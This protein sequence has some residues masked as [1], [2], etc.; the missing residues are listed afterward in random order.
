MSLF[1]KGLKMDTKYYCQFGCGILK[2]VGP[3]MKDF[4]P[5]MNMLKGFFLNS[6]TMNYGSSKSA[7]IVQSCPI[8]DELALLVF[9]KYNSFL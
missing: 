1:L 3:K 5:R 6:P 4:C 2:M 7:D 8:F 9:S